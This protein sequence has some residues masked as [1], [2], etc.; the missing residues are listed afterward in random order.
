MK[1]LNEQENPQLQV[2]HEMQVNIQD[3]LPQQVELSIYHAKLKH[4]LHSEIIN[5]CKEKTEMKQDLNFFRMSV[6]TEMTEREIREYLDG[7][8]EKYS[9]YENLGLE[10]HIEVTR[11]DYGV[12]VICIIKR[13]DISVKKF[14]FR[15]R[16]K[17]VSDTLDGISPGGV[18]INT[19][20]DK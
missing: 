10:Y 6:G 13:N 18:P 1:I 5:F 3:S 12:P 8:K 14:V 19:K 17:S 11:Y 15:F 16:K 20:E 2:L 4:L 9:H 7:L